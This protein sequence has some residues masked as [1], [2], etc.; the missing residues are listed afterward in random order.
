[1]KNMRYEFTAE[2]DAI[3]RP[4]FD[5][6]KVKKGT[7]R[8]EPGADRL[9][10]LVGL[11]EKEKLNSATVR[12]VFFA[13][14]GELCKYEVD[15]A[16]LEGLEDPALIAAAFEGLWMGNYVFSR[17][18]KDELA[19]KRLKVLAV[20]E[21]EGLK[22][23]LEES[24]GLMESADFT[25]YLVNSRAIDL[26]PETLAQLAKEEL[27]PLGVEVE[28][29]GR[30]KAEELGLKAFLAVAEGSD[31]EPQVIVAKYTGAG[32]APYG[33]LIGKGLTYDSGGYDIKPGSGMFTMFGDMAGA[34][35]VLGAIRAVA[36]SKL[37]KNVV[38]V[39]LAC[40]NMVDGSAYKNG[41]IIS[42]HLG[43]TIEIESTD[44]EGRLTLADALSYTEEAFAPSY[45]VDVATLTGAVVVAL[46]DVAAGA[47]TNNE[48]LM[49]DVLAAADQADELIW[50]FP[51][52]EA[53]K[54][55]YKSK[56]ADLKN[57]GGRGAGTITAGL[58]L[59]EF[60]KDTPWVHL[61]VAGVTYRSDK[62]K[63]PY[64]MGASGFGVHALY[65]LVK[66]RE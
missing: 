37:E 47:V 19:D 5:K 3:L 6:E 64:P 33:A 12:E 9:T 2:A 55:Q 59:G 23:R 4:V 1:M 66:N 45:M 29:L 13:I 17:Y 35:T 56:F 38:A 44:A 57:T 26:Y 42:S 36:A 10:L 32:D 65:R 21:V 40:E 15:K 34:A 24:E 62:A 27:E 28:I 46:G 48:E 31:K 63:P 50:E 22:E 39:V 53:Y 54:E 8:L 58:F 20:Q 25:R 14:P 49:K 11:G 52:Y 41:D 51:A 61:D 60:V 18:K 30:D 43:K 7:L 16:L